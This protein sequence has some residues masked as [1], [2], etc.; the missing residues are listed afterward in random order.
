MDYH[1]II[2]FV[3]E[4]LLPGRLSDTI[5]WY[6]ISL[7]L[8]TDKHSQANASK[9]SG[10]HNTL[11]SNMLSGSL[12][13]STMALNRGSRRRLKCLMRKRRL[14]APGASWK[15]AI[16]VDATLHQRSSRHLQNSQKFNHGQGWVTGHQWTNIVIAING[17]VVPLPPIAFYTKKE[18]R[19]RGI[20]Y[21]SEPER[22][23]SFLKELD[24]KEALGHHDHSEVAVLMDSGYDSK[25]LQSAILNKGWDFVCS[26][27]SSRTVSSLGESKTW[28][29]VHKYISRGRKTEKSLRIET[30]RGKKRGWRQFFVKQREG[31]L[32]GVRHR[33]QLVCSKKSTNSN[34][35]YI[36]CSN[37][38]VS[39]KSIILVYRERWLV[40]LFHRDLKSY[41]G[42][43]D[44][45]VRKFD[46]LHA[47][48]HWVYCAFNTLK[49]MTS[50]NTG[51]KEAQVILE[52][53]IKRS[54]ANNVIQML[55]RING[56]HQV[57]T[58]CLSV[59][60][61]ID[62]RLAA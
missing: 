25:K 15:I 17:Q 7:M 12:E 45:G 31:F 56:S 53:K 27:K 62:A 5:S 33:V 20:K 46:S 59:I 36:A 16:I 26:L 57:K 39:I 8:P 50:E 38:D 1:F 22:V 44:A 54:E 10:K 14:I 51:I 30:Y 34:L 32:K 49:E 23:A 18:C 24:L 13:A 55:S 52:Q 48:I 35:K 43:E 61:K 47:H 11:F 19:K 3:T 42:L 58:H 9:I 41:L 29:N 60:Q 28:V 6:L 2:P 4:L 21:Q 40:E 37:L